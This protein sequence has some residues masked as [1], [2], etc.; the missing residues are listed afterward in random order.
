MKITIC[1]EDKT[2]SVE[3]NETYPTWV[4]LLED[5]TDLLRA[6][7]YILPEDLEEYLERKNKSPAS[8]VFEDVRKETRK[9]VEAGD[10]ARLYERLK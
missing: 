9:E 3:N 4:E 8:D 7:G 1:D 2:Y 10:L 6:L 5:F